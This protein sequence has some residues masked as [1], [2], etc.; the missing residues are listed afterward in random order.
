MEWWDA[1]KLKTCYNNMAGL[2][3][4]LSD[5]CQEI[6]DVYDALL[7]HLLSEPRN[8]GK[9]KGHASTGSADKGGAGRGKGKPR[10]APY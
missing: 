7:K 2:F 4:S 5:E 3:D 8:G 9:G 6:A 1:L 10:V